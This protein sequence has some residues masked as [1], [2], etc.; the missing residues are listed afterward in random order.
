[1]TVYKDVNF[2]KITF[3]SICPKTI[4]KTTL[5]TN[6]DGQILT[7]PRFKPKT[8][9]HVDP[10][11]IVAFP[12][13]PLDR[14][15]ADS[16][17][18]MEIV[19]SIMELGCQLAPIHADC[20]GTAADGHRRLFALR[21]LKQNVEGYENIQAIVYIIPAEVSLSEAY[22]IL[23]HKKLS[24]DGTGLLHVF[25]H[26]PKTV[27]P[28][29]RIKFSNIQKRVGGRS[30]LIDLVLKGFS[31]N[32]YTFVASLYKYLGE[33][34]QRLSFFELCDWAIKFGF[35]R[36][37]N[38][39]KIRRALVMKIEPKL[40]IECIMADK[41]LPEELLRPENTLCFTLK[42]MAERRIPDPDS[43]TVIEMENIKKFRLEATH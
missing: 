3:F 21:Y 11:E 23:N 5:R 25:L 33:Y 27:S 41:P 10:F 24:L 32:V 40:I 7:K 18:V 16:P 29:K 17:K 31:A 4:N 19:E 20:T 15:S 36:G 13:N 38:I 39:N 22:C 2:D 28:Q 42:E 12:G 14:T 26:D 43:T 34:T 37:G 1:M 6:Q 35:G 30:N 9:V 8:L